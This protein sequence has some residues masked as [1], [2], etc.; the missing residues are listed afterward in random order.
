MNHRVSSLCLTVLVA[1]LL[2]FQSASAQN[3]MQTGKT[4]E[5]LRDKQARMSLL[6]RQRDYQ[7]AISILKEMYATPGAAELQD[8]WMNVLYNLACGYAL[9]GQP[10]SA[11][12]FL[13]SAVDAGWSDLNHTQADSDLA[14]LR[15]DPRFDGILQRLKQKQTFWED[16]AWTTPYTAKLSED[17]RVA[18]LSKLWSEAKYNFVYFDRLPDLNWDSLYLAY[19]PRVRRVKDTGDYYRILEQFFAQ[20][21]DGHTGINV[22]RELMTRFFARPELDTRLVEDHV[23]VTD[24]SAELRTRGIVPGVEITAIDGVPVREYAAERV[25]PYIGAST[26]QDLAVRTYTWLLLAGDLKHKLS[27]TFRDLAGQTFVQTLPR[28]MR[29]FGPLEKQ[30]PIEFRML[31]GNIAYVA[32]N[33]FNDEH[34]VSQFDS[35]FPHFVAADGL[36]LDVRQNGGGNSGTGWSMLG[37]LTDKTFLSSQWRTRDYR[38]T[39]RAWGR[40]QNWFGEASYELQPHATKHYSKPVV[41]L[42]G[43]QTYSAAEDFCA[44]FD[45]M[46]RGKIIGEPTGGSTGQP[47]ILTLPGGGSA[48]ICTKHDRYPDGTEFVGLGIIPDLT[49]TTTADDIRDGRDPVLTAALDELRQPPPANQSATDH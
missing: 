14:A 43:P 8:V 28:R 45:A 36:I 30:P 3:A 48:R 40:D 27:I 37:Y 32:L 1:G 29:E 42:A 24:A 13:T 41:V 35:L 11:F 6:W 15:P 49:V 46:Q 20:L 39:F 31:A 33:T 34:V 2:A 16:P 10:D 4:R 21:R 23:L 5:L 26:P 17:E 7:E 38:P 22:P 44:V 9:L 25:V 18:G 47:L 19:L 12:Y